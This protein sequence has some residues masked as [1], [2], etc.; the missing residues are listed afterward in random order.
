MEMNYQVLYMDT[1]SISSKLNMSHENYIEIL[2]NN[3]HI[4]GGV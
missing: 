1:D 4:L 2:E 3:K